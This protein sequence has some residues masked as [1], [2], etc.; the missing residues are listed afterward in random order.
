MILLDFIDLY[1]ITHDVVCIAKNFKNN[2][3]LYFYRVAL[4]F[5]SYFSV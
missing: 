3:A 4:S 5:Q 1:H 2:Y